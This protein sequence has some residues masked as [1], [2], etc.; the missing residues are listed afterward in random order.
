MIQR[1]CLDSLFHH[2]ILANRD[3][4]AAAAYS[5]NSIDSTT[6]VIVTNNATGLDAYFLDGTVVGLWAGGILTNRFVLTR[7]MSFTFEA[8]VWAGQLTGSGGDGSATAQAFA[9][10]AAT[11]ISAAA[12]PGQHQGADTQGALSGFYCFMYA[13]SLWA[14][15]CPPFAYNGNNESAATEYIILK[16][17]GQTGS[18]GIIDGSTGANG[19]GLLH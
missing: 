2:L 11:F 15:R 4:S 16:T 6:T 3:P 17:L 8:G 18:G 5:I 10:Q 13:Y 7:D 1:I 12:I 14:N 9:L 19:G